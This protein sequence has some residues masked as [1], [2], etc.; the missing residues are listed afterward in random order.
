MGRITKSVLGG[1]KQGVSAA[2]HAH[3]RKK[4]LDLYGNPVAAML[5]RIFQHEHAPAT[6]RFLAVTLTGGPYGSAYVQCLFR[7]DNAFIE[8]SS[9]YYVED[10]PGPPQ[11]HV[12]PDQLNRLEEL[13]F[14]TDDRQGNFQCMQDL[15]DDHPQ[16]TADLMLTALFDTYGESADADVSWESPFVRGYGY[17][18]FLDEGEDR[19]RGSRAAQF[20]R[21]MWR[22]PEVWNIAKHALSVIPY[23]RQLTE[24][25]DKYKPVLIPFLKQ[26]RDSGLADEERYLLLTCTP[27][28]YHTEYV[29][30]V[31]YGSDEA[32]CDCLSG[33]L[34]R[35]TAKLGKLFP[36]QEIEDF[37]TEMI[38]EKDPD[39]GVFHG[40]LEIED[41]DD[42]D[43][44]ARI[45]LI[46]FYL[47]CGAR[48]DSDI[49]WLCPAV[50]DVEDLPLACKLIE[51]L[52]D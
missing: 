45:M 6:D 33:Y 41:D 51:P 48:I 50:E 23:G 27:E 1:V 40:C 12:G 30:Y 35:E 52:T 20:G 10:A 9:G 47:A 13:G 8:L 2:M 24:F 17:E 44:L 34:D 46:A 22:L 16:Q 39:D 4:F 19:P 25:E 11:R 15:R 29:R 21:L 37:L 18:A 7:G 28:T 31:F 5:Q 49:R 14:T 36:R 43:T 32:C 3:E 26:A 38:F 42:I